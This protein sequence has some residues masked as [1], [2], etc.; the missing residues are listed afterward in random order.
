LWNA[1]L[2]AGRQA[3]A[4]AGAFMRRHLWAG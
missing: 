4:Q 3:L 2:V 1:K